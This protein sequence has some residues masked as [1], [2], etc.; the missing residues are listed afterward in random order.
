[1]RNI[2]RD[3][4]RAAIHDSDVGE[5]MQDILQEFLVITTVQNPESLA[6]KKNSYLKTSRRK[7]TAKFFLPVFQNAYQ[8]FLLRA[9]LCGGFLI[10]VTFLKEHSMV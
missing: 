3:T 2:G 4:F 7:M 9:D 5:I 10:H 1:M 6:R 8:K